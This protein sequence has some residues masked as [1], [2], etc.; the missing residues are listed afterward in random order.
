MK[1]PKKEKPPRTL[2]TFDTEDNSKGSV[3]WVNFYNGTE[4]VPFSNPHRAIEWILQQDGDFWAVNLEYDLINLFGPLLDRLTVLTYGGFGLLKA[5]VYKKPVKFFNTLRHWPLSVAE[6]G[7]RLGFPKLP[8]DPTNLIYCQRDCEVTYRFIMEML[9]RYRGL[10]IEQV[11]AT[12]PSTALKYYLEKFCKVRWERHGD[13]KVWNFLARARYG[14]RTEIFYTKP[15]EDTVYE[16]DINSSYP[17]AMRAERF[18]DLDT[19]VTHPQTPDFSKEGVATL[20]VK[21][22]TCEFPLLPFKS[23]EG[24]KLLFPMGRF[25]GSWTYPEIRQALKLGYTIE[26]YHGAIEY[27]SIASPFK[28]Y[29]DHLYGQRKL[30]KGKDELMS[31]VLK[32][33][34]NSTF[35]KF[36]EEGE[37]LVISRGVRHML[38]QVP[39]HSN[40][41]W[42]AYILAYGRLN[43][44]TCMLKASEKGMLLYVDTDSV[45][46][47]CTNKPFEDSR[48]LGELAYKATYRYAH[49]KL[50]KLYRVDDHY[51]AKG[52]PL[53]KRHPEDLER[54]KREFF[55]DGVAEFMKPYRWI[56]SKKLKEQ[57]NVWREVTKQLTATYDKR[58]MFKDGTTEPL[59]MGY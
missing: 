23:K 20:T 45:F 58:T 9:E 32:L 53:D 39:K 40:M 3:Y 42:A 35:G 33:M 55:Y 41:I 2:W 17:A 26:K 56:E 10:G 30:M 52:V 16:Y 5:T 15:V 11:N 14:G 6:M 59:S 29:I 25:T 1:Q 31:Y 4:H 12:L 47:R 7:D 37:L 43:L 8:F 21:A 28:E 48:E 24:G 51:K 27:N 19:C 22:P 50:P 34:M 36:G 44:H 18:P 49:F 38:C 57:A 46:V 54:L 13:P